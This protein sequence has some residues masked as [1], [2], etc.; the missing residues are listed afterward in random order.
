MVLLNT[1]VIIHDIP[2]INNP[3]IIEPRQIFLFL[4]F[5]LSP[6][7]TGL[8][9]PFGLLAR[10][11]FKGGKLKGGKKADSSISLPP[12]PTG[13]FECLTPDNRICT[14]EGE[15]G[16]GRGGVSVK[17]SCVFI[18]RFPPSAHRVCEKKNELAL[19][20]SVRAASQ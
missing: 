1:I 5:S 2:L 13:K 16:R 4:F 18:L 17:R 3:V 10:K 14:K 15:E 12:T 9:Q 20:A 7:P 8:N 6:L 11:S 19:R